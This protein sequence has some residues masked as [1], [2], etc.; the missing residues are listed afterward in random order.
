MY[1]YIMY[2]IMYLNRKLMGLWI[3]KGPPPPFFFFFTLIVFLFRILFYSFGGWILS[4]F[5]ILNA[6]MGGNLWFKDNVY[7]MS[8][9]YDT[10]Y[11]RIPM[12]GCGHKVLLRISLYMFILPH[13]PTD[14]CTRYFQWSENYRKHFSAEFCSHPLHLCVLLRV[15][16]GCHR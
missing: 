3:N 10:C 12:V 13:I 8:S 6:I 5:I 9:F 7:I 16:R 11:M 1:L 15:L 4:C 2:S 14:T